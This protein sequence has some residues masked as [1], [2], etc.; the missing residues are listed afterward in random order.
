MP[1]IMCI[2]NIRGEPKSALEKNTE[3]VPNSG[4]LTAKAHHILPSDITSALAQNCIIATHT[5]LASHIACR[6]TEVN[7]HSHWRRKVKATDLTK[8]TRALTAMEFF[9]S[10]PPIMI[11]LTGY[12]RPLRTVQ[13][14][15]TRKANSQYQHSSAMSGCARRLR[16]SKQ[17]P[18]RKKR[19][20]T[21][22]PW[23]IRTTGKTAAL[24]SRMP[25]LV[26]RPRS[27]PSLWKNVSRLNAPA[28][29]PPTRMDPL[30]RCRTRSART[31]AAA[32]PPPPLSPPAISRASRVWTA[33]ATDSHIWVVANPSWNVRL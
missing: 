22:S 29:A 26:V 30:I 7:F 19:K 3:L 16:K 32:P 23:V 17:L 28:T 4:R 9:Q 8:A 33:T 11:P 6:T 27:T 1:R 14:I 2:Q 12:A 25:A 24:A 10:R 31:A 15:A 13:I 20:K 21:D 5:R 18:D